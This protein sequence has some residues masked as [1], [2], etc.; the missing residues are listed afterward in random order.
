ME[1]LYEIRNHA[2]HSIIAQM[3]LPIVMSVQRILFS[4]LFDRFVI[5]RA[6]SIATVDIYQK[7]THGG[8]EDKS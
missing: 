4:S 7:L 1:P 8:I 2:E 3:A 6:A 5:Y